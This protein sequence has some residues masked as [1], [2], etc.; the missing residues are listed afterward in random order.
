MM[1]ALIVIGSIIVGAIVVLFIFFAG[2]AAGFDV[3]FQHGVDTTLDAPYGD[4]A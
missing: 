1:T 3:G 4:D 2:C